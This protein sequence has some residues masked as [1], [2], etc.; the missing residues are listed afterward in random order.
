MTDLRKLMIEELDR[1]NYSQATLRAYVAAV[2]ISHDTSTSGPINSAR[3]T[4]VSTRRIC[5]ANESSPPT[6]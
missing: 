2:G 6:V 5:S 3:I 4:F 1:R